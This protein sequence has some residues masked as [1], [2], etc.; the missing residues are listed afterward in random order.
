M[1]SGG[2]AVHCR[3]NVRPNT[4]TIHGIIITIIPTKQPTNSN[5]CDH[6]AHYLIHYNALSVAL[7]AYAHYLQQLA[8]S[9]GSPRASRGGRDQHRSLPRWIVSAEWHDVRVHK[10]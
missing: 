3:A 9:V 4:T 7:L 1:L 2:R 8:V 6:I 5:S 10:A